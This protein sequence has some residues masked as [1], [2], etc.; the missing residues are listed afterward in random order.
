MMTKS[1]VR[2][3]TNMVWLLCISSLTVGAEPLNM[4]ARITGVTVFPDRAEVTREARV[5]LPAGSS[6][7]EFEDLPWQLEPDSVRVSAVGVPT[8]F[9]AIEVKDEAREPAESP[10]LVAAR[11]ELRQIQGQ[12]ENLAAEGEVASDLTEFLRALRATATKRESERLGEGMSDAA[13]IEATYEFVKSRLSELAAESVLRTRRHGDLQKD[14]AVAQARVQAA[15]PAGL[16]RRKT[17]TV[18]VSASQAGALN[19]SLTYVTPGASWRPSYRASLDSA[20]GDVN[21][22]YEGVV[23]QTTG[24]DWDSVAL[25]LSTASP[26]RGVEP[27]KLASIYLASINHASIQATKF[28]AEFLQGLP[29]LGRNYQDLLTLSE[30][31]VD[32]V[33][34]Q[35]RQRGESVGNLDAEEIKAFGVIAR[36]SEL[37]NKQAAASHASIAKSSY[38][39]SFEV[40][41]ASSVAADG[42]DHRVSLQIASLNSETEYRAV[43]SAR[44]AAYLVA[45][46]KAPS[47]YPLLAGSVRVFVGGAYLGSF[48]LQETGPDNDLVLPFGIDNRIAVNRTLL[49]ETRGKSGLFGKE[50][51]ITVAYRTK[52][53]NRREE[54]VTVIVEERLPVAEEEQIRVY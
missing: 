30:G 14:L 47:D 8:V 54:A 36:R 7:I 29:L 52:V 10:G 5:E 2:Q 41:N 40:E 23:N 32:G 43:P 51:R 48:L 50:R 34:N 13:S 49:P 42:R 17:A 4:A 27:Q 39:V 11:E 35:A 38:N 31:V 3:I 53:E 15:R 25:R 21:L 26:V 16:I 22:V 20:S 18:E 9:G 33:S 6:L 37:D 28:S 19:V 12:L 1:R 44:P 46:T 45:R 24:E